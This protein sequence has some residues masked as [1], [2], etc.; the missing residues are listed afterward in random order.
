[1]KGIAPHIPVIDKSQREDGTFS[2]DDFIY[3]ETRDQY[4]CRSGK[5]LPRTR[6][7]RR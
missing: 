4:V 5:I 3:D 1:M 7:T 2:R 6:T